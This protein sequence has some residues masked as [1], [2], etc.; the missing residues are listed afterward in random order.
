MNDDVLT[1]QARV[2]ELQAD[3]NACVAVAWALISTLERCTLKLEQAAALRDEVL[4]LKR[5]LP[6]HALGGADS[7]D[8]PK[9]YQKSRRAR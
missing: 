8:K 1:L 4:E 3:L 5:F 2:G 6:S 9:L 7:S